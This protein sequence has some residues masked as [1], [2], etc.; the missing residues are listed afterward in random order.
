MVVPGFFFFFF[1]RVSTAQ[2]FRKE[3][4]MVSSKS[5]EQAGRWIVG[6]SGVKPGRLH[7][8]KSHRSQGNAL[9]ITVRNSYKTAISQTCRP[10]ECLQSYAS[11]GPSRQNHSL[12]RQK[13]S[14]SVSN[15]D[16]AK[17]DTA[18]PLRDVSRIFT[19][20]SGI[21]KTFSGKCWVGDGALTPRGSVAGGHEEEA[22]TRFS[23]VSPLLGQPALVTPPGAGGENG[24]VIYG[25]N[26]ADDYQNYWE[27]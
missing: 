14:S 2:P 10:R 13:A 3:S 21:R 23:R 25:S 11:R 1:S 24:E 19:E 27:A 12:D 8:G 4:D 5:Q 17:G 18:G 6:H 26:L 22:S 16:S 15:T 7:P 20:R 9:G